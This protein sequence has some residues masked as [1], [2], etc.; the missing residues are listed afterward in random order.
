MIFTFYRALGLNIGKSLVEEDFIP[1]AKSLIDKAKEKKVQLFLPI[2]VVVANEFSATSQS[3]IVDS[4]AIPSDWLGLDI[5]P[6]SL[7]LYRSELLSCKTIVWNGP[8]GVFEFDQYAAGTIGIAQAL[9]DLT[10]QGATTVIGG[11]DSV[12]AVYKAGLQN[13]M[14]H[15]STGGGASLEM[16]EGK[17]LPGVAALND[18]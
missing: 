8:M 15:I 9:A 17:V 6:K 13:K 3:Q 11:G 2:D 1:L 10:S 4:S 7:A 18:A 12:A 14:S 16:L 5:G